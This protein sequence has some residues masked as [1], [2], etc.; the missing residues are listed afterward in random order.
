MSSSVSVG[1]VVPSGV[2]WVADPGHAWLRV[3]RSSCAGLA[4]SEYSYDGGDV[5][6]LEQDIDALVWL[7]AHGVSD[8]AGDLV[9]PVVMSD[10]D[11]FVR[12]L[13]RF[14]Q[15]GADCG[16]MCSV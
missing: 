12:D 1:R 6:Y 4:F 11:C 14:G 5:L 3:P 7:C 8:A 15:G 9:F 2:H 16:Y 10:E 13:P